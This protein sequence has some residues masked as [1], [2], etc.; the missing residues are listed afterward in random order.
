MVL[1]LRGDHRSSGDDDDVP[2]APV[3]VDHA[4]SVIGEWW[5]GIVQKDPVKTGENWIVSLIV[6]ILS[7]TIIAVLGLIII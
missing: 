7:A 1:P 3:V 4:S 2:D 5:Q 6:L